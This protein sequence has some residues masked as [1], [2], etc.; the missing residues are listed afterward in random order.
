MDRTILIALVAALAAA[1]ILFAL[2]PSLDLA[3]A[4]AFYAD[5]HFVGPTP[6]GKWGR[7]FFRVVPYALLIVLELAYGL[8][9][10]GLKIPYAPSGRAAL[11][12]AA[13]MAIGPGLI[14]NLGM[15][16]H[17]HRPRP[18]HVQEFG[19]DAPFKPWYAFD[20]GCDKN[21]AFASGEAAQGFW[22]VAPASLAPPPYRPL[23]IG[24]AL[25][26]GLGASTLR[27]A[28]GGHFLSDALLGGLITLIVVILVNRAVWPRGRP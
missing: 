6:L 2:W 22:M 1:L 20:G 5:G 9:R 26:F 25:V 21:C 12:L 4:R 15:K 10:L 13:T 18:V 3:A 7:E 11:F 24:A 27:L 8:S 28:Y 19:G 23:A 16:D 14:V 17:L